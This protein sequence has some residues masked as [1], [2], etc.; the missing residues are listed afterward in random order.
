MLSEARAIVAQMI[1]SARGPYRRV[2]WFCND[3]AVLPPDPYACRDHGGGRQHGEYSAARERLAAL[4]WHVGTIVAALPFDELWDADNGQARLR[5]LPLETYLIDTRDG[6]VMR[7]ARYYRGHVQAEDEEAAGRALLL[8]LLDERDWIADNFLLLRETARALPHGDLGDRG[9]ELRRLAQSIAERAAGFERL[10]AEVHTNPSA[11]TAGRVRAWLNRY[12]QDVAADYDLVADADRLIALLVE[13]F[14]ADGRRAR[15]AETAA[16]LARR[17]ALAEVAAELGRLEAQAPGA[18]I[19]RLA[20]LLPLLRERILGQGA[21]SD[22][23]R[24][25]DLMADLELE[26]R[27]TA[28]ERIAQGESTRAERLALAG[29]LVRAA[30]ATGYLSASEWSELDGLLSAAAGSE[31]PLAEYQQVLRSLTLAMGWGAGTVRHAF[32]E[33]LARYVSLEPA[34]GRFVDDLLRGSVL[35]SLADALQPLFA[36]VQALSG[37]RRLIDG[38]SAPGLVGLNPGYARGRLRVAGEDLPADLLRSDI[39]LL[40]QTIA[41]LPPVAG[42]LTRGEG[43]L[44]SHVQLLAR[45][46]GIPNVAVGDREAATLAALD[47][48]SV[49][50]IAATDGSVVIRTGADAGVTTASTAMATGPTAELTVPLPDLGV[51]RP[52]PIDELSRSL[53][54]RVVGPK[55]ANLGELNRLFPGRVAPAIALPFG[56]FADH[57][58]NGP[59]SPLARLAATYAA[60]RAGTL[61]AEALAQ[62]LAAIREAIAGVALSDDLLAQLL[63]LMREWFGEPGSYGVFVRS[64]TNVEDLPGFTG[65]GLSETVPNVRG[66]DAQLATIPRVWASVLSPR[67]IAWR[68]SLLSNPADVYASVLLMKSVPADKSGVLVTTD[69]AGRGEGLTVSTAWGVGGA[70]AGEAAETLTLRPDGSERLISEA[71]APFQRF[72]ADSGGVRWRRARS[73]AVLTAADRQALRALAEEV[74]TRYAAVLDPDGRPLPWDIEF[75]FVDG[76]LTLFQ[77]RPLI[78]RGQRRADRALL[79]ALGPPQPAVRTVRLDRVPADPIPA[80]ADAGAT[81]PGGT[82]VEPETEAAP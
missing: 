16:R 78:E 4:G 48:R 13:S 42:V 9:R 44:L 64:D 51:R 74:R 52:L 41:E 50:V 24:L 8:A 75:G 53:S 55:A 80:P 21:A 1:D 58:G 67:A 66:L 47:G 63:P 6:W 11:A 49:E 26:T 3:G 65:A 15:L 20:A 22:R 62:S 25:L 68:S 14:D 76:E 43:N 56:I 36:D 32:A 27:L 79:E 5:E 28:A 29:Q 72:L 70:V 77:I 40:P 35:L 57:V 7:Q 10:R 2:R 33:A 37:V 39:V 54:G 71:K 34:A 12:Q 81:A 38:S 60:S 19:E 45:N 46:I 82:G 30:H 23:L 69:L 31:L 73:G 17:P 18:R 59:D 61:S